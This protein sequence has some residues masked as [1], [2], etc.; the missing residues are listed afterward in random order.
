MPKTKFALGG[1]NVVNVEMQNSNTLCCSLL[2]ISNSLAS[3]QIHAA[4]KLIFA[5][6]WKDK[7]KGGQATWTGLQNINLSSCFHSARF[8]SKK[9]VI[10]FQLKENAYIYLYI[11]KYIYLFNLFQKD[12]FK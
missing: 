5:I 12:I 9:S 1:R 10:K 11:Y 3:T 8:Q 6:L 7:S 4:E 2:E